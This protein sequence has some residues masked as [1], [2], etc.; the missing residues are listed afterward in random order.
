MGKKKK[1]LWLQLARVD[2]P[3]VH[4]HWLQILVPKPF[5]Q[6]NQIEFEVFK[7]SALTLHS[8]YTV[9]SYLPFLGYLEQFCYKEAKDEPLLPDHSKTLLD[10]QNNC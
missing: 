3:L 7:Y 1:S 2:E 4:F 8:L 10:T 5:D 6:T 9:V